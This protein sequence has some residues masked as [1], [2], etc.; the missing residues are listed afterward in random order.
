M[1]LL[2]DIIPNKI[3]MGEGTISARLFIRAGESELK[4]D[5]K[6]IFV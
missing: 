5:W 6:D 2:C 4:K 1:L 3:V